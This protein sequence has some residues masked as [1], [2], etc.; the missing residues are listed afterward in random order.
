[1]FSI[2]GSIFWMSSVWG[3]MCLKI[4]DYK[5][6]LFGDLNKEAKNVLELGIGTGP[7]LKF[8]AKSAGIQ[9]IGIDPNRQMEKFARAASI[10]AGLPITQFQFVQGVWHLSEWFIAI[11]LYNLY[12]YVISENKNCISENLLPAFLWFLEVLFMQDIL[13]Y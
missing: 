12:I 13:V 3:S 4:A 6:Q 10:A 5:A 7:N 11:S 1:M 9:V 8:Y 2:L